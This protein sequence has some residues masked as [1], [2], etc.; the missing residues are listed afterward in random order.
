MSSVFKRE[1]E[2]T[3]KIY[4]NEEE[5]MHIHVLYGSNEA[6]YWLEPEVELAKNTGIP[7][8][9]LNEIRK[10]VERYADEFKKQFCEHIGKR[11]D[12]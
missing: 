6:K 4:S 8:H 10:I 2:Y 1:N 12:D 9:K 3:F 11:V 7:E 5:R